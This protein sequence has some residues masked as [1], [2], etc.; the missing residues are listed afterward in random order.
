DADG[1][2][3][4]YIISSADENTRRNRQWSARFGWNELDLP[5]TT[6]VNTGWYMYY[7]WAFIAP[8][9]SVFVAGAAPRTFWID[10]GPRPSLREGPSRT[11]LRDY[12]SAVMYEPG[13]IL[14]LG[15][16]T[17]SAN[18]SENTAEIIDLNAASPAWSVVGPMHY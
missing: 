3:D 15:G 14:V 9:G 16:G 1:S 13:R 12:G 11:I 4:L 2:G 6:S 5:M 8:E 7:P 17:T 10:L 18:Q